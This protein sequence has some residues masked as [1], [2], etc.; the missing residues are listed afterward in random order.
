M[1]SFSMVTKVY[2]HNIVAL[3]DVTVNI[4]KGEF[5][6]LIGPTGSGKTT[7]L[8]LIYREIKPTRGSV[9]VMG[10]NLLKMKEK[11][12]PYLRRQIGF[13]FQDFKLLPYK[14]VYENIA[15]ALEV[16]GCN[17]DEAEARV[18]EILERVGL[19]HRKNLLPYQLSGGERQRVAIARALVNNPPILL[20]DEPTGNLDFEAARSIMD[21]LVEANLHGTTVV[22]ATHNRDIVNSLRKRVIALK[23]GTLVRDDKEGVYNV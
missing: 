20:A 11:E 5:V 12:I 18:E 17:R 8:R 15:F 22:V 21:L 7:F 3:K 23:D 2:P 19:S 16:I 13:V 10:E 9:Y 6:F 1:I 4:E 14:T